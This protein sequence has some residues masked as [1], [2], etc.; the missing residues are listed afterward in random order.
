MKIDPI[1]I[2][3]N[4]SATNKQVK[5]AEVRLMLT[6]DKIAL[7]PN[8]SAS[9]MFFYGAAKDSGFLQ[10]TAMNMEEIAIAV[11]ELDKNLKVRLPA[12]AYGVNV[13]FPSG[14][15]EIPKLIELREKT[16]I[17]FPPRSIAIT[18]TQQQVAAIHIFEKDF[19][20]TLLNVD[21]F[22]GEAI[23]WEHL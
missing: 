12:F 6:R 9:C 11:P 23:E 13:E 17:V 21:G 1:I 7:Y 18:V 22:A 19:G 4:I 20:S 14:V 16:R 3:G 8:P 15:I 10:Y 5:R 2:E